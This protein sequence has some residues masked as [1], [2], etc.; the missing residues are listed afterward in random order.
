MALNYN[1]S[2]EDHEDVIKVN[3]KL[4]E[5]HELLQEDK[6]LPERKHP[7]ERHFRFVA[8]N[9]SAWSS[10][11]K[12]KWLGKLKNKQELPNLTIIGFKKKPGLVHGLRGHDYVRRTTFVIG[13]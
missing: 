4:T 12:P 13:L 6:L 2:T 3:L 8:T 10:F 11:L 7:N 5:K 1:Y 9:L